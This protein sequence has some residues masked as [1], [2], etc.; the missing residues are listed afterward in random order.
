MHQQ[1]TTH[2]HTHTHTH[3]Y[4]HT[5][6]QSTLRWAAGEKVE[7]A[8]LLLWPFFPSNL[9]SSSCPLFDPLTALPRLQLLFRAALYERHERIS[10]HTPIARRH[11][12]VC[13]CVCVCDL[14]RCVQFVCLICLFHPPLRR[15][16]QAHALILTHMHPRIRVAL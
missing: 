3:T 9:P 8:W 12:G 10:A 15:C 7:R 2:R 11:R 14:M 13:V 5:H 16:S 1:P 4:T 6:T